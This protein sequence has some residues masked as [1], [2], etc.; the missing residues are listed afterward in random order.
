MS[1][2]EELNAQ[3][4]EMAGELYE[5]QFSLIVIGEAEPSDPCD[6]TYV[7]VTAAGV[8]IRPEGST[9]NMLISA[10]VELMKEDPA[11]A[12][13]LKSAVRRYDEI[14]MPPRICLN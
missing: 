6:D 5:D 4:N 8:L 1:D 10:I 13:I 11:L 9:P 14:Q 2:G 12:G 7:D 3:I